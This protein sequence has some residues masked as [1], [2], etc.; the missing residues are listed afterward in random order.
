VSHYCCINIRYLLGC[1]GVYDGTILKLYKG[2]M[3][4]CGMMTE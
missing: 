3:T 1:H 4:C 2:V